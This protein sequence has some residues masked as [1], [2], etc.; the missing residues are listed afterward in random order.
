MADAIQTG[1][2]LRADGVKAL[3]F[4]VPL[5][6]SSIAVIY[7]VGYFTSAFSPSSLS[8]NIWCLRFKQFLSR[9]QPRLAFWAS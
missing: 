3:T 7:D 2:D 4:L 5:F 6:A 9:F 8:A 1:F